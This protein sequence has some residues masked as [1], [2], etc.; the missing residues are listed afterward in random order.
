MSMPVFQI[1]EVEPVSGKVWRASGRAWED[2]RV[3]DCLSIE[4]AEGHDPGVSAF[5]VTAIS[6]YGHEV[7]ELNRML[8]GTLLLQSD[9]DTA[10]HAGRMLVKKM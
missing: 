2:V 4:S 3:G 9:E 5:T 8:T 1:V 7:E 10:L 6:T